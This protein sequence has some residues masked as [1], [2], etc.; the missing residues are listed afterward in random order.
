M[1]PWRIDDIRRNGLLTILEH[2]G[3]DKRV[4]YHR[5]NVNEVLLPLLKILV[6]V[7]VAAVGLGASMADLPP[8]PLV[9][10]LTLILGQFNLTFQ[11]SSDGRTVTLVSM[12][13]DLMPMKTSTR[14]QRSRQTNRA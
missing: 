13:E 6:M 5:G 9:D 7:L 1:L 10:R 12:P 3:T 4:A 8:L 14:G 11:I 2:A